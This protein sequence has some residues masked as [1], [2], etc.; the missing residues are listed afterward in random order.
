M[1]SLHKASSIVITFIVATSV[2]L[3]VSEVAS[4]Q[5]SPTLPVAQ[6]QDEEQTEI[7]RSEARRIVNDYLK[8]NGK[9]N[10]RA[11]RTHAEGDYW[12]VKIST[13]AGV[14]AGVLRVHRVSGELS[15]T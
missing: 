15:K 2:V 13:P 9:R 8:A 11:G 6:S 10:L 4:A 12:I 3:S 7:N 5:T 1:I 14:D